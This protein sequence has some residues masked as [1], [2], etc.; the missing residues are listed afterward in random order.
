MEI[1]I[2]L[3]NHHAVTKLDIHL[4]RTG[5]IYIYIQLGIQRCNGLG[6]HRMLTIINAYY[7]YY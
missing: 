5:H 3:K 6:R 2:F 4:V 1:F 7:G